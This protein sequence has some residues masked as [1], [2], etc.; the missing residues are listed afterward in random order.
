[1]HPTPSGKPRSWAG[2]PR[3]R[4]VEIRRD[5]LLDVALDL[6]CDEGEAGLTV[7]AVSRAADLHTRYF[8]ESFDDVDTLLAQLFDAHLAALVQHIATAVDTGAAEADRTRTAIA[9]ILHFLE[10]DRRRGVILFAGAR[11][12]PVLIAKRDGLRHVVVAAA[13]Q[14]SGYTPTNAANPAVDAAVAAAVV[15][16]S[17]E[18]LRGWLDGDI[19]VDAETMAEMI[20][21][22]L[23]HMLEGASRLSDPAA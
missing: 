14:A 15:G 4:R 6:L 22:L 20:T 23:V 17:Q 5:L 13:D 21:T 11:S 18:L 19:P 10:E 2:V 12:N 16:A 8:Y 9:A 1:V 3:E 7:R